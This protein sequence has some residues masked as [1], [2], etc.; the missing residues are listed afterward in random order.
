MPNAYAIG[1]VCQNLPHTLYCAD[2]VCLLTNLTFYSSPFASLRA[3]RWLKVMYGKPPTLSATRRRTGHDDSSW[4]ACAGESP[5]HRA[6]LCGRPRS[7]H[8]HRQSCLPTARPAG[9]GR[10]ARTPWDSRMRGSGCIGLSDRWN[11]SPPMCWQSRFLPR[12]PGAPPASDGH[13][14]QYNSGG[15]HGRALC[16]RRRSRRPG[17]MSCAQ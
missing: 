6:R 17:R 11:N 2:I 4:R 8:Q 7:R 12:Y 10:V 13:S 16:T 15:K 3:A 5:A 14:T 9:T 1:S